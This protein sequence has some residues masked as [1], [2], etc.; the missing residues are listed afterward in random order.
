MGF[1]TRRSPAGI[2]RRIGGCALS[3]GPSLFSPP[4]LSIS[5]ASRS[6]SFALLS[7]EAP[8][9]LPSISFDRAS[10]KSLSCAADTP[11]FLW[12]RDSI[13]A[14][15]RSSSPL[16]ATSFSTNATTSS[17]RPLCSS[18]F[19]TSS[20]GP[21]SPAP[22]PFTVE[23]C[24]ASIYPYIEKDSCRL[25]WITGKIVRSAKKPSATA[26]ARVS[27]VPSAR[28]FARPPSRCLRATSTIRAHQGAR[29]SRHPRCARET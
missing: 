14:S 28:T 27:L 17:L 20:T 6:F 23:V 16:R 12:P 10:T 11:S 24:F 2:G 29:W 9:S 8:P 21:L 7:S 3:F 18:D 15:R 26:L 22:A 1:S 25:L 5:D 19:S 4:R 13:C